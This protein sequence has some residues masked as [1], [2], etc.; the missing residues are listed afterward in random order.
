M[1]ELKNKYICD[2]WFSDN[3]IDCGNSNDNLS[4]E[5]PVIISDP[6]VIITQKYT[7]HLFDIS[8][9]SKNNNLNTSKEKLNYNKIN[10]DHEYNKKYNEYNEYTGYKTRKNK[11]N[12][13]SNSSNISTRNTEHYKQ[14]SSYKQNVS[15]N[16][17]YD[18][19]K[20]SQHHKLFNQSNS[21]NDKRNMFNLPKTSPIYEHKTRKKVLLDS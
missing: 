19:K 9:T 15:Y 4:D 12:P 8:D 11:S 10:N 13:K 6:E 16:R 21:N 1:F 5:I 17:M 2:Y 3:V 20:T 7:E 14:Y 18:F